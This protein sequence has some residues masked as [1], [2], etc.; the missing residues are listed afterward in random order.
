MYEYTVTQI[1]KITIPIFTDEKT[2]LTKAILLEGRAKIGT[3]PK[4]GSFL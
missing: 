2:E 4:A 1:I 3:W